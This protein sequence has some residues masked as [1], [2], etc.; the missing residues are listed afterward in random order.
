MFLLI[1][2]IR[3]SLT[4]DGKACLGLMPADCVLRPADVDSV[5]RSTRSFYLEAPIIQDL[6]PEQSTKHDNKQE[7]SQVAAVTCRPPG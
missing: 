7:H 4:V 1:L 6:Q 2:N 5:V 3:T